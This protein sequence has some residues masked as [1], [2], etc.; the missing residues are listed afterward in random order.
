LKGILRSKKAKLKPALFQ[1]FSLLDIEAD[2]KDS[3]S[4]QYIR[5]ARIYQSTPSIQTDVIKGSIVLFLSEI[6]YSILREEEEREDLY[7]FI[8]TAIVWFESHETNSN[9]HLLFLLEITKYLGFYPDLG[10]DAPYFDLQ[11]GRGQQTGTGRYLIEGENL[12]RLKQVL[13]IKFDVNKKI[14]MS[15][16]QK[17]EFLGMILLYFKLHLDGFKEPKSLAVFNE[18]FADQ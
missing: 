17:R 9:F 18:V 2:H 13:G 11:E 15:A 1:P 7:R 12:T 6:L 14:R 16:S 5:E 3:R 8:E 10:N 4:L